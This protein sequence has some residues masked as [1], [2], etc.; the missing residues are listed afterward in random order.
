MSRFLRVAMTGGIGVA[1]VA[2]GATASGPLLA[3]LDFGVGV[4]SLVSLSA[5][6]IWGLVSTDEFFL[7]PRQRLM[8]QGIH[9][10]LGVAAVCFLIV[11]ISVKVAEG[12]A[13]MFQVFSPIGFTGQ[14][15]LVGLGSLAAYTMILT[16]V[17][18]AMRSAFAERRHPVRWRILHCTSYA[19]WCTALV[20]GLNA[21]RSAKTQFIVMYCLAVIG[22]AIAL[23][24]RMRATRGEALFP[25]RPSATGVSAPRGSTGTGRRRAGSV[26]NERADGIPMAYTESL[27]PLPNFPPV[28]PPP[29]S[30]AQLPPVYAQPLAAAE[31]TA[32]LPPVPDQGGYPNPGYQNN[33][34]QDTGYQTPYYETPAYGTEVPPMPPAEPADVSADRLQ[35]VNWQQPAQGPYYNGGQR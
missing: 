8:T 16:A 19:S 7:G 10:A 1:L 12:H 26:P 17:T 2:V 29:D 23:V 4:L 25:L 31:A 24:V 22:V 30:L 5:A 18:G 33:G 3:F 28:A 32:Q 9:R 6:V 15:F 21:G 27:P 11:H 20:H 34:Y 14:A 35:P 13:T